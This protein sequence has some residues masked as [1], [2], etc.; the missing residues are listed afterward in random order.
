MKRQGYRTMAAVERGDTLM[1]DEV[2]AAADLP[3]GTTSE[4]SPGHYRLQKNNE[5]R[6]F[7]AVHGPQSLKPLTFTPRQRLAS[8]RK[9]RQG[10]EDLLTVQTEEPTSEPI[11]VIG[12]RACDLAALAMQ[13][14]ILMQGQYTDP[15]F[16][17]RQQSLFIVAVHCTRSAET[18]F[19]V[20][21]QT[22]PR[23]Q[24]GF[25]I[26]L[27][28]LDDLFLLEAGSEAGA[29]IID[30]LQP[31]AASEA[32][33]KEAKQAIQDAADSQTRHIDQTGLPEALFE[34][35]NHPHWQ[36]VAKRCLSCGN[37]TMVCPT[38]FCHAVEEVP[39]LS[40]DESSRYRLWDSCFSP[41]HGYIHGKNMRPT[42]R[43]RYRMWL[44]HKLGAWIG[45]FGASGCVGCGRCISWCP[46]GIDI[47]A[48]YARLREKP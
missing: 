13:Q 5:R 31:A 8:I 26:A 18:C 1:W 27:T 48:E 29:T 24:G 28:E 35:H 25:D 22:G 3:W 20:S 4:Q 46:V 44:T 14:K 11:A 47:T 10:G 32:E 6:C 42:T 12:V 34:A 41:A 37:C 43:E 30:A 40:G 9:T 21:M 15:H 7:N 36:D 23:A 2:G 39:S 33:L 17:S 16:T 45:Q 38:C 19:C